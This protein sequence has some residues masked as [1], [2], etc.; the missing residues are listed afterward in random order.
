MEEGIYKYVNLENLCRRMLSK[1][2]IKNPLNRG[3][4][5]D[6]ILREQRVPLR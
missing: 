2:G 1:S 3:S 6:E 4:I 5:I